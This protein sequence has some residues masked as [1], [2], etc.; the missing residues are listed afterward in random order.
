MTAEMLDNKLEHVK[1]IVAQAEIRIQEETG[2]EVSLN[3]QLNFL[4]EFMDAQVQKLINEM[5]NTW[6]VAFSYLKEKNRE[7][8]RVAMRNC[9]YY[10]IRKKYPTYQLTKI[11]RIFSVD[12]TTVLHALASTQNWIDTNDAF[13]SLYYKPVKHLFDNA[14]EAEK[15]QDQTEA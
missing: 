9:L 5:L 15:I 6:G 3:Y 8:C 10:G 1:L 12:H 2:L 11:G 4:I 14:D 7:R 13:F